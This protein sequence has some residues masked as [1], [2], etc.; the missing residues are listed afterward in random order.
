MRFKVVCVVSLVGLAAVAVMGAKS[1]SDSNKSTDWPN[2]RGPSYNGISTETGWVKAWTDE[3]ATRLW[4]ASVGIGFSSIAVAG[5]RAYTMGNAAGKDTVYC[6]NA[7]S[8]EVVWRY[9]YPSR[10]GAKNYEG[11]TH[12][13]PTVDGAN[14]YTVGKWGH[15]FC[16]DAAKGTVKWKRDLSKE[17]GARPPT[18][19]FATSARILDNML[20]LNAG[21][22]GV[23]LNKTTGK[24][25]WTS[26]TGKPGYS[27]PVIFRAGAATSV[28]IFGEKALIA[29]TAKDGKQLWRF[30][31]LTTWDAN[32]ADPIVD[33]D[34]IFISSGYKKGCALLKVESG[35]P[36]QLWAN[37]NMR[38]HFNSCVL[39]Q[40]HIYGFDETTLR[41]LSIVDGT[42]KWNRTGLGKGS[43]MLADGKLIIL[44]HRGRLVIAKAQA[45][46]FEQLAGKQI[47]TG[48]CWTT[49]VLSG[50]RIYAR[51]T[52]GEVVCYGEK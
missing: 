51:N 36:R 13:T 3:K 39:W 15:V 18:W 20:L 4:R 38:N 50:G 14:V 29:V 28:L 23:A 35:R 47:L 12:A 30:P 21:T 2:W 44:S 11:G 10:K 34:R 6:F 25:I 46:G 48:Q 43:L 40:Q 8:G 42:E 27:T 52:P 19:G 32:A 7:A 16:F 41:C 5:G 26:G 1:A 37:R 45:T 33:G 31:W 17:L 9:S 22:A 24:A 49:P